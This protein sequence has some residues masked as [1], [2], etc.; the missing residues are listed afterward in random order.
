M[1]A[2]SPLD[3]TRVLIMGLGRFGGGLGAARYAAARAASVT[4]TDR[5]EP[6][7]LHAAAEPIRDLV[8]AGKVTL[9]PGPHDEALLDGA[10]LLVV[11]PAVPQPWDNPFISE[12]RAR[13]IAITT[14]ITLALTELR[15]RVAPDTPTVA[16]TGT[17]GKSTTTAMIHHALQTLGR[18]S[19][20][21]GNIGG[22]L[23]TGLDDLRPDTIPVLEL[24]SAMLHWI[25]ETLPGWAP[26]V[27][28]V[29]GFEPN[30]L[31]WHGDEDHYRAAKQHLLANQ[32]PGDHAV[33]AP[34]VG[35]WPT[36]PGVD[37]CAI[38]G[39]E[40]TGMA[41]PG[42]HNRA[43]AALASAAVAALGPDPEKSARAASSFRGLPHRL[44]SLGTH[45]GVLCVNDSKCTT[46]A[47]TA[48]AVDAVRERTDRVHLI[49]GGADKG[50][51]L[52]ALARLPAAAIYTIG[53]TGPAI[54]A[55]CRE[56]GT[57]ATEAGTLDDAV[58]AAAARARAGDALLLSP[59]CASWDQFDNYERR[60]ERFAELVE[61]HLGASDDA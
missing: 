5:A 61:R 40:P 58:S 51:D 14:E 41:L 48:I 38:P 10:D 53:T 39:I 47:A 52:S 42:A 33:L 18:P 7:R 9:I 2:P 32:Q 12:A 59:A 25:R 15:Q 28:V 27:A 17:A 60:G 43:N 29:T 50:V 49:A 57:P 54:A 6:D 36:A 13:G 19:V 24:S 34:A 21:G 45:R 35:A 3:S 8:D 56:A 1:P 22:S 4:V 11:N 16:V 37:R 23:L 55:A 46:V 20:L 44:Q 31:D 30:H 26:G